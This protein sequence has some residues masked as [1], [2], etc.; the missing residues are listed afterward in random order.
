MKD[1]NK[2]LTEK[3]DEKKKP[4]ATKEGRGADDKKYVLMMEQYKS[5]RR[6]DTKAANELLEKVFKLAKE[7]DVSKQAITAGAYI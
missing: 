1:L 5:L 6:T 7:G 3:E 4:H 2:F